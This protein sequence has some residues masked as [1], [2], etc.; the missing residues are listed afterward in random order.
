MFGGPFQCAHALVCFV[1]VTTPPF[2]LPCSN[3]LISTGSSLALRYND[4]SVLENF[5]AAETFEV[6]LKPE[7]VRVHICNPATLH[8][9]TPHQ[10]CVCAVY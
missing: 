3:Y 8:H 10:S 7:Y 6:L 2:L 4:Y 5:H 9:T 1:P